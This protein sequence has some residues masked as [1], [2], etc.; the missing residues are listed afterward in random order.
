MFTDNYPDIN[1]IDNT[2]VDE[3]LTGMINDY[4]EKYK[5]L[6]GK[7][8]SLAQANPY[9]LIMYACT[10]QIY[11]AM[12]YADYAGKMSFLTYARGDFLDN[13]A[14]LRGVRRMEKTA[15]VT[16]LQFSISG[17][18]ESALPIPAGCRVTNGN[19]V[20]FATDEYAEIRARETSI[21]VSAT[22]TEPGTSG[23]G[24]APGELNVLVN[25]LPYITEVTNTVST[26]G[27]ANQ[28]DDESLKE[29]IY[30]YQNSYSTSGPTGAYEYYAKTASSEISDVLVRSEAPGEVDIYFICDGGR[31]PDE[32]LIQKVKEHLDDRSIRPLTDKITVKAPKVREYDVQ[33]TYYIPS[34]SKSTV[35]TIQADVNTAVSIYNTWQTDKI[36]RDINPSYLI[37]KVMEAGAKRVVVES[38][39]F[40]VLDES[41]VA[42]TGSVTVNFGGV[43]DD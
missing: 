43:E 10:M 6:T 31:I 13:L 9:R 17:P 38:P 28:E 42:K 39:S 26:Y 20:F 29:R 2:T 41:T 40:I 30:S 19:D 34:S 12:Q 3:V 23:N 8:V 33:I 15:A 22:C 27:G 7:E 32:A 25:T 11:Q 21:I 16:L 1:F 5:E 4:Q 24:F 14:A 18:I 35:T 36:G 37:Q